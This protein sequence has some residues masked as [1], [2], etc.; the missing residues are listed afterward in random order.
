MGVST[1]VS[2]GDESRGLNDTA[3]SIRFFRNEKKPR[4]TGLHQQEWRHTENHDT[5]GE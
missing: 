2:T 5:W 3:Q 1:G 4:G